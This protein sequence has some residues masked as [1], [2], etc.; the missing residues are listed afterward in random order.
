MKIPPRYLFTALAG[1]A[2]FGI[3]FAVRRS[4]KRDVPLTPPSHSVPAAS[5][6]AVHSP[7]WTQALA[8]R[9]PAQRLESLAD[10][11]AREPPSGLKILAEQQIDDPDALALILRQWARTDPRSAAT[12]VLDK[13]RDGRVPV[14]AIGPVIEEWAESDSASLINWFKEPAHVSL[15]YSQLPKLVGAVFRRDPAAALALARDFPSE[16]KLPEESMD[17]IKADPEAATKACAALPGGSYNILDA[18]GK[19]LAGCAEKDAMAAVE[20]AA[21]LARQ[22]KTAGNLL[23]EKCLEVWAARDPDA[24]AVYFSSLPPGEMSSAGLVKKWAAKDPESALR[25]AE[26]ANVHNRSELIEA[27]VAAV[28]ET[29]IGKAALLV[30]G[31]EDGSLRDKATASLTS[32]WAAKD[33]EAA[34]SWA[35]QL[36]AGP[37]RN[38]SITD[39]ASGWA[40]KDVAA[41]AAWAKTAPAGSLPL[42][43]Y[44][45]IIPQ[46]QRENLPA[47]AAWI[48]ELPEGTATHAVDAMFFF[49][50]EP[51]VVAA[52]ALPEGK[53]KTRMVEK[54]SSRFFQMGPDRALAWILAQP[55]PALRK[56]MRQLVEAM[57]PTPK[58]STWNAMTREKKAELLLRMK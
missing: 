50:R 40:Y 41:A 53:Y 33:P 49:S 37:A 57:E 10:L 3:A 34:L 13:S 20:W 46:L 47:A 8:E 18:T 36:P 54:A 2:A 29:D 4:L 6:S 15:R 26:Q 52:L 24:A 16:W 32:T 38:K 28:A 11:L 58:A 56:Q 14:P 51:D 22:D 48:N 55:D 5:L 31:M 30:S 19:A 1:F 27:A 39:A 42:Q 7:A 9:D 21:N 43:A 23:L 25:W 12:W 44:S 45:R 17:W 35:T